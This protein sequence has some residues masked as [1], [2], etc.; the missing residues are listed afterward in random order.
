LSYL[1]DTNVISELRKGERANPA[2]RSWFAD[3]EDAEI[4][5]SALTVGEIRRG[6]ESVRRRDPDSAVA[7]SDGGIPRADC[8]SRARYASALRR[9]SSAGSRVRAF[10]RSGCVGAFR[11]VQVRMLHTRSKARAG[12]DELDADPRRGG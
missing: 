2:V 5:L 11:Y 4:F 8:S 12:A 1:V 6:I 9:I 3:V 7:V 10:V